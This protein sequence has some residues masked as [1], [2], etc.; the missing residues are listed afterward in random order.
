MKFQYNSDR[1]VSISSFVIDI[2]DLL[3]QYIS[4][5]TTLLQKFI[6]L[7]ETLIENKRLRYVSLNAKIL[8]N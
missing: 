4:K 1:I 6:E 8:F 5:H 3:L 7:H 2:I